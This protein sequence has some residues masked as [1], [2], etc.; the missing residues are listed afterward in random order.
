MEYEEE[1]L[2]LESCKILKELGYNF[3]CLDYF[4]KIPGTNEYELIRT[5]ESRRRN[6]KDDIITAYKVSDLNHMLNCRDDNSYIIQDEREKCI[7]FS[8]HKEIKFIGEGDLDSLEKRAVE[9]IIRNRIKLDE[10][11]VRNV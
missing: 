6:N 9:Y 11:D 5:N 4:Q 8:Y 10:E 2:S 7:I 1:F 3:S